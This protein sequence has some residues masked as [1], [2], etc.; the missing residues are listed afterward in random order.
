MANGFPELNSTYSA[1]SQEYKED[2]L[3]TLFIAFCS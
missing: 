1:D 2:H 3:E